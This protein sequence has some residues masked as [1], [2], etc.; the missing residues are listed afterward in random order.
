MRP[1]HL[2]EPRFWIIVAGPEP[3]QI[4]R[5]GTIFPLKMAGI[6]S[7]RSEIL[8]IALHPPARKLARISET[9]SNTPEV[10]ARPI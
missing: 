6:S 1:D 10:V 8:L 3:G 2:M 7:N 9:S 5:V 4:S